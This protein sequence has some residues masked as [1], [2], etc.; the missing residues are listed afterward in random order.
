[1]ERESFQDVHVAKVLNKHFIPVKV[2]REERPD[3]DKLYMNYVRKQL[4]IHQR[5]LMLL[6]FK[7]LLVLVGGL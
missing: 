4:N 6:R 1:M 3:I 5:Y 2:D 7:P